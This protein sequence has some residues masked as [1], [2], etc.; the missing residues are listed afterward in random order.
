MKTRIMSGLRTAA[1]LAAL[2]SGVGA[3]A[4]VTNVW[5]GA[6][7]GTWTDPANWDTHAVPAADDIAVFTGAATVAPPADFRGCIRNMG[8][9]ELTVSVSA[10]VE[11]VLLS[12][13]VDGPLPVHALSASIKQISS[14]DNLLFFIVCHLFSIRMICQ[15]I[16]HL[17]Y[18][19][20]PYIL[21][22]ALS[23]FLL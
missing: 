22:D 6:S 19:I 5:T 18:T 9:G 12:D 21:S 11:P 8:A 17:Y 3:F 14:A 1:L 4:A 16:I 13:A 7:S 2:S 15:N 10:D 20:F 23:L